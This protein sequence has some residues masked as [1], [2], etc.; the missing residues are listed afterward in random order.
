MQQT[1]PPIRVDRIHSFLTTV[2]PFN[3][4]PDWF[5]GFY[6]FN[7]IDSASNTFLKAFTIQVFP[8]NDGTRSGTTYTTTGSELSP[9]LP[10]SEFTVQTIPPSG[11]FLNPQRSGVLPVASWTCQLSVP[12]FSTAKPTAKRP[13]AT[14]VRRPISSPVR[15][16]A[17]VKRPAK[18][19]N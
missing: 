18:S 17:P 7:T 10:I 12:A 5:S 15:L 11:V 16:P 6:A 4:S 3:P 2:T 1:L 9:F 13:V 19:R 8:W 14:P